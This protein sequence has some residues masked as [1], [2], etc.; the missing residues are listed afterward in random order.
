MTTPGDEPPLEFVW[1][2]LAEGLTLLADLNEAR[3]TLIE[4]GH[5]AGV[6]LLGEEIRLLMRKLE[7][8]APEGDVDGH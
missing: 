4:S 2:S 3:Q 8:D 5:L 6:V 7:F 1:Y